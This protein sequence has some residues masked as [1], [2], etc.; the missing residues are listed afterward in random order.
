[1]G[2][3]LLVH[4]TPEI[5]LFAIDFHEDLIDEE[6]ITTALMFSLQSPCI[7]SSE[8]DTPQ[9]DGFIADSDATLSEDIF[10]ISMAET[11]SVVEPDCV[12]DDIWWE[13]VTLICV[14]PL[15]LAIP[16]T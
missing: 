8:L 9:A 12:I 5:V 14:H 1:M 10:D 7:K 13:S 4:C 3:A 16:G 15:I 11:E 2:Q 6:R